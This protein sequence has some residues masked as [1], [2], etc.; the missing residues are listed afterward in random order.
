MKTMRMAVFAAVIMV[1]AGAAFAGAA[2]LNVPPGYRATVVPA[3]MAELHYIKPGDRLDM[4]VT[5]DAV[6]K[7]G[8]QMVTA[9]ILQNVLVLDTVDKG[10]LHAVVLALNPNEA[11]YAM[12]S[13]TKNYRIN[14]TLRGKGDVE[15]HP[16]EIA[17]F[18]KLFGG[19]SDNKP[20]KEEPGTAP[21]KN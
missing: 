21:A 13:L 17:G 3:E 10:G 19:D 5:F 14:F 18:Q 11:Q 1:W 7:N 16:M 2:E 6:L 8:S 4:T 9:T 15:M 12:L 20:E